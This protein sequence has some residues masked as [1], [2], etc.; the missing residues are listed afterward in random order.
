MAGNLDGPLAKWS[1]ADS[2]LEG[3]RAEV[4]AVWPVDKLWPVRARADRSGHRYHFYLGELPAIN[5][6]WALV[7]GEIL[8]NLRSA[9]DHLAYELHVRHYRGRVPKNIEGSYPIPD[10]RRPGQVEE[11]LLQ[12]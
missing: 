12:D 4:D 2:E 5:P 6:D 10:L 3:L 1:R 8:F 7:A 9:L 11:Q